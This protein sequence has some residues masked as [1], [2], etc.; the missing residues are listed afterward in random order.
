MRLVDALNDPTGRRKL[1]LNDISFDT[2]EDDVSRLT[3]LEQLYCHHNSLLKSLPVVLYKLAPT[4]RV[5]DA[6]NCNLES[7]PEEL[8]LL[9]NLQ[10][11]N[12]SNNRLNRFVWEC[13]GW[14]PSLQYLGLH[15]NPL[16]YVSPSFMKLVNH[17]EGLYRESAKVMLH[18]PVTIELDTEGSTFFT[19]KETATLSHTEEQRVLGEMLPLSIENC[20]VCGA[21]V[22]VGLPRVFVEFS[23]WV[24]LV[25]Q[26]GE[27]EQRGQPPLLLRLPVFHPHCGSIDCHNKIQHTVL[28]NRTLGAPKPTAP[29]HE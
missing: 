9:V 22:T 15:G 7:L 11:L 4:L 28:R 6:R 26:R 18:P 12:V 20:T 1:F 13:S 3:H 2:M 17:L 21:L 23:H 25:K 27:E 5:L 14:V 10:V 19:P 24:P 16:K 8:S 29:S